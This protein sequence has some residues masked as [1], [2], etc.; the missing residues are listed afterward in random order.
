MKLRRETSPIVYRR[1]RSEAQ[2]GAAYS[3]QYEKFV[4]EERARTAQRRALTI[5]FATLVV[6]FALVVGAVR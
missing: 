6:V 5:V 3:Y 2:L 1:I 4:R